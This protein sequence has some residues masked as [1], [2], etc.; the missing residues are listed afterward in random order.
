M[1]EID[2]DNL[3]SKLEAYQKN[4]WP[5]DKEYY[6]GLVDGLRTA[7][8]CVCSQSLRSSAG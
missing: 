7:L 5:E 6:E 3:I 4:V 1:K 8:N 2:C